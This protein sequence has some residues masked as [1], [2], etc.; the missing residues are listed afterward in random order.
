M[1]L[2][3]ACVNL[4]NLL[5]A[6]AAQRRREIAIRLSLGAGRA[7]I[8]RQLLTESLILSL[9]GGIVGWLFALWTPGLISAVKP[10]I[11][12]NLLIDLTPDW[13]V[14]TFTL[15]VS[16]ITCAIFGLAP[17]LHASKVDLI[18][19]LKDEAGLGGYRRSR[20]RNSLVVAQVALSLLLLIAAGLIVRSL[21]QTLIVGPGFEVENRIT[22]SIDLALQGYDEARGREFYKRLI[23]RVESLPGV[24][25][26]SYISA[27][28]LN[29]SF[30][31]GSVYAEG[32][33]F[34]RDSDI[35]IVPY[36]SVWPR[37]FETMGIP[38]IAGSD[39]TMID[40]KNE[41]GFAI[42]NETFARRFWPG[43][44]PI[45]KH[46]SRGGTNKP[47][48]EVIGVVKDGKY[49]TLG[50][51]PRPFVYFPMTREYHSDVALVVNTSADPHGMINTIRREVAG[52]DANLPLYDV[53]TM[54]EH[55]RLS[56]FLLRAG[57]WVTGGFALMALLL[58]GLGIYGVM[59][60]TV[61]QRTREI[62]LRMALGARGGEVMRLVVRQ[63]MWLALIGLAIGLAGA[64]ILTRLMSSVL[65]GVSATD[66]VTFIVVTLLL[67]SVVLIACYLPA[68]RA[69]KVDP[70]VA[71]RAD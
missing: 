57:A 52:L 22:M 37:Y 28:P 27:L 11:D 21:Q 68:R 7:R 36:E 4:A 26:A 47:R 41:S 44:N 71:L 12:F 10:Q 14:M 50:E 43:Q 1:V 30:K 54:S 58:A 69:A 5:L 48:V 53:K 61:D 15:V 38:F 63:G 59:A 29:F 66:V 9:A 24:R 25:A 55:M 62:G 13:R 19:A 51:D 31:A 2:L 20:I 42:V 46:L 45:G 16:F 32:Q 60:Y 65:Y 67:G 40:D 70:I 3:I 17:A 49:G 8:V 34:N 39:F 6:Q 33:P 18:P 35:P 64:L 23:T 56:L